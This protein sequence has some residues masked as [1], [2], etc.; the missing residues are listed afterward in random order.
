MAPETQQR[1]AVI[2]AGIIGVCSALELQKRGYRVTL[3]DARDPAAGASAG[4][5]GLMAVGAVVP[6]AKPGTFKKVPGWLLD[7]KGPL[8]IRP[9]YLPTLLPWMTRFLMAA[10]PSR[11]KASSLGLAALTER[12]LGAYEPW[13][14]AAGIRDIIKPQETLVVYETEADFH[15]DRAD[16]EMR[17]ELGFEHDYVSHDELRTLEPDLADDFACAVRLKGWVY[18]ADPARLVRSLHGLFLEQ[19]GRFV[20]GRVEGI[21]H[22]NGV[23]TSLRVEGQED[24]TADHVVV[25]AGAWSRTLAAGLGDAVPLEALAGYSTTVGDSGVRLRHPITYSAGGFVVTPMEG[26]LRIGGT[27]EMG[28]LDHSP[29][30]R[31]ART[32]AQQARRLFPGIASVEGKEWM[33]YRPFLPDTL[34]VIDRASRCQNVVYAFG[35]GQVG[36]TMGAITGQL[37]AQLVAGEPTDID[38]R[39]YSAR[40]FLTL[41]SRRN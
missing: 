20:A 10:R 5:C 40:R 41:S 21:D 1:V 12:A 3:L 14:E 34:P 29:D 7:A 30:F 33:G 11:V 23:A 25:A 18:F 19:G 16:L 28:G 31:R 6:F 36:I 4:N 39:P 24:M 37:V 17:R 26:G 38:L 8:S 22:D 15:Q 13:L 32:I 2:G 35:H 9:S 27:I